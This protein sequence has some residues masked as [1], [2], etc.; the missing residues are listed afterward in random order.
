MCFIF[1]GHLGI[2]ETTGT[3]EKCNVDVTLV[4]CCSLYVAYAMHI[5]L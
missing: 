3:V 5:C 2:F 4:L 1:A